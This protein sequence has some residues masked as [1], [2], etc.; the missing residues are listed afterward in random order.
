MTSEAVS[1]LCEA[2]SLGIT[3]S[4]QSLLGHLFWCEGRAPL[5]SAG[6]REGMHFLLWLSWTK[7]GGPSASRRGLMAL[8]VTEMLPFPY[9]FLLL[10][11]SK[12]SQEAWCYG[13]FYL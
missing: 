12:P 10:L 5:S 11:C 2:G 3:T 4:F 6:S 7:H 13:E 1:A 9:L 8:A